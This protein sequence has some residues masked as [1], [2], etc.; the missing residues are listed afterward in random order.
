[1]TKEELS[2]L[3]FLNKE[4]ERLQR[5][6]TDKKTKVG[7]K[8]PT[9]SDMPRG[10]PKGYTDDIDEIVDLETTMTLN[11]KQ[12]QRER[13]RLEKYI[14]SIPDAEI[15]LIY[16]LRHINCMTFTDIGIELNMDRRTVSRKYFKHLK[17]AHNA[18]EKNVILG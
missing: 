16:R 6:I 3:F 5:D 14:S 15:R 2:Q 10:N 17:V 13:G 7:Y 11:L 18:R 4:C 12:I 1:L 8:S 9:I